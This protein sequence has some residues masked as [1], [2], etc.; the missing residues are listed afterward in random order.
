MSLYR[1]TAMV[2]LVLLGAGRARGAGESAAAQALFDEAKKLLAEGKAEQ[3][4]P[5]LEES[6]RLDP[7]LGTL[8]NLADCNERTGRIATAWSRF[9]EVASGAR[10]MGH[11]EAERV[12]AARAEA[13]RPRLPKVVVQVTSAEQSPGLEIK[14]NGVL[15]GAAQW[16]LA[17]PVDPGEER[18]SASAP[19]RRG[20]EASVTA[21]EAQVS[22]VTIPVLERAE[23]GVAIPVAAK[24]VERQS[25]AARR[26]D[27]TP[28]VARSAGR[29]PAR[30]GSAQR[31]VGLVLGGA[32]I[33]GIVA[34]VV[35]G[36]V[37]KSEYEGA[38]CP[39][40]VC[41]SRAEGAER[42]AAWRKAT[43]ATVMF[44]SGAAVLGVGGGLYLFAPKRGDGGARSAGHI[45]VGLGPS[46]VFLRG[47]L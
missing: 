37:A 5:K 11:E 7:G 31:T 8:F 15:V 36:A 17:I 1:A 4:C 28:S 27:A 24:R 43:L 3:A 44:G 32:G 18:V 9:V 34:S 6:Q 23:G 38:D 47:S 42:D 45:G 39:G 40:N 25:L 41:V 22:T 30:S 19:G 16:G 21:V 14:R 33:A 46:G 29:E 35:V 20:F 2:A 12:A 26:A 10:S 13:L